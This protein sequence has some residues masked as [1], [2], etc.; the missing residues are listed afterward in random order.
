MNGF[1]NLLKP[2]GMTSSDV[3]VRV[4]RTL[5]GEKVGHAGTLDPEAA[6]VLPI[7]VGKASRLF[8]VLVDKQKEYVAEIA[9]GTATDTQD[10][11]GTVIARG[12]PLPAQAALEAVLPRFVG[13]IMQTPPAYSAL[14]VG[15]KAAYAL[16][17]AGEAPVL[18]QRPARVDAIELLQMRPPDGALLRIAC[19]KGVYVRT[20]CHDMGQ[21]LACGAHM[22]FLLRTQSGSFHLK[23]SITLE[24]WM[25]AENRAA[26]LTPMEA[27]L[28]HLPAV[29]VDASQAARCRNGN[30][31]TRFEAADEAARQG[32]PTRVYCGGA[33]AGIG[34]WTDEG[35]RFSAM[36]MERDG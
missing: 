21:A 3:V 15:G 20:L 1:I 13:D 14:K 11:Q 19:G 33:F 2:P 34:R 17:R 5:S 7:M 25:D 12:G 32:G 31:L 16:A 6:G 28:L 35:V 23:D 9:F 24:A 26:L 22:R 10:A 36:L 4:R 30:V 29:H 27:P 18:A 8:D